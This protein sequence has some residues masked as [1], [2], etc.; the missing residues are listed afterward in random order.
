MV[1][2]M[3]HKAIMPPVQPH[4]GVSAICAA[5]GSNGIL[6]M[7]EINASSSEDTMNEMNV[8]TQTEPTLI[9]IRAFAAV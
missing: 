2:V 7:A 4:Q 3:V 6:I 9:R 8:T 1:I 5:D